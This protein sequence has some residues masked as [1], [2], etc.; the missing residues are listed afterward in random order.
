MKWNDGTE[1]HGNFKNS[2]LNGKGKMFNN[3]L[4]EKYV[5]NFDKNEF[6][7]NGVYT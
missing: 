5:G 2:Y 4:K 1:Y 6:N 3:I 7:G